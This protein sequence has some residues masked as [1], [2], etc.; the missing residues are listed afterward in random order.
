MR[1]LLKV[2][3]ITSLPVTKRLIVVYL[4]V[5]LVCMNEPPET[6]SRH[7]GLFCLST[8]K[9]TQLIASGMFLDDVES[10]IIKLFFYSKNTVR[11]SIGFPRST[12]LGPYTTRLTIR[13]QQ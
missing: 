8:F 11:I 9:N 10:Y 5:I 4:P 7:L 13:M 3:F 12:I 6:C 2:E 1:L